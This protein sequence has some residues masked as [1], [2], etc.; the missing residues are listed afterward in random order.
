[1]IRNKFVRGIAVG[2]VAFLAALSFQSLHLLQ[3]LEWKSWDLRQKIFA[4]PSRASKEIVLVLIDQ[5]S[6]DIYNK[7]Q[8]LSWPWPR[9]MYAALVDYLKAGGAAACFFDIAMT[10]PSGFGVADDRAFQRAMAEAGNVFLPIALTTENRESAPEAIDHLRRF[11]LSGP[12][13]VDT[14]VT[15]RSVTA[16]LPVLLPSARGVGN[17]RVN[18]DDDGLYRRMPLASRWKDMTFPSVPLALAGLF[19]GQ[20]SPLSVP[21]DSSG[22]MILRFWG[23]AGSYRTYPMATLI[24]SYAQLEAGSSPQIPP[25]EFSGKIV[26]V[27][28]S[29]VGL[30]DLKSSPLS[31]VISGVEI[32]AAALDTL[33][34]RYFFR[35]FPPAATMAFVLVLAVLTGWVLSSLR[36]IGGMAAAVAG[37]L[38]VPA[39]VAALAFVL[40]TWL[41][42]V[43]P[44]SAV[45]LAVIGASILNYGIE[46]KKRR[47]IK[48]AFRQY[49]SPVVVDKV[50]ANPSGLEL[51][52]EE[53]EITSFFSDVE[54]FTSISEKL[55]PHS[56]VRLMNIY[57]SEMTE[58][59]MAAGGTLDKY[60]GDAIIAFWNAPLDDP[61]H[62]LRACRA[63]LACQK[64][65]REL[66]PDFRKNFGQ[67]IRMR[68]GLNTGP[69]VVGNFGSRRRFDYTAVGDTVN[70]AS[71]LEGACKQYRIFLLIGET[72]RERAGDGIVVR[73]ADLV[74]V[75]GRVQP[76]RIYELLGEADGVPPAEIETIRT[77][78]RALESYRRRLWDQARELFGSLG[79]D[80]LAAIYFDRCEGF[81][82]NPPPAEWDG[83]AELKTK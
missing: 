35:I 78:G 75:V 15:Y 66:N 27:G 17:V 67:D 29:A 55:S 6:L 36:R 54:G 53:R 13:R 51:G 16:P 74:R 60:E 14:S 23:P 8:G 76:A 9:Q 19:P 61:D 42:F 73:E 65:T 41:D 37:F 58:I 24:N 4:D 48:G 31:A 12:A 38:A 26:L 30:L 32:Q 5:Y 45:L 50:L 40:G 43:F 63:A 56:L 11:S 20:A 28:L 18:P 39:A 1:M 3:P 79:N 81:L 25:R 59:I 64:R 72:T 71:R 82:R 7:E 21:L 80:P 46:G 34:N 22:R 69:A 49:L 52:G 33:L 57:L 44:E 68:I 2:V 83:V 10:E 77:Y 47:F 70:L 62:A